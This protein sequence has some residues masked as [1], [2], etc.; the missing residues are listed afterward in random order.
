[1]TEIVRNNSQAIADFLNEHSCRDVSVIELENCSWTDCFVIA[2]VNSVGHLRGVVH[3]IWDLLNSLGLQV[4]NRHKTPAE[5]GWTLIDT[6]DI[7]IHLL[8]QA[9]RAF[10]SREKLWRTTEEKKED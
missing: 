9:L 10:S 4:N 7:V 3:Q 6:G 1:M 8:S 2:T 5:D